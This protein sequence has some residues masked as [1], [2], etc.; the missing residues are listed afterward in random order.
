MDYLRVSEDGRKIEYYDWKKD[1]YGCI[2]RHRMLRAKAESVR[3]EE[4]EC[5]TE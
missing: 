5:Q 3:T 4:D 1:V 2:W